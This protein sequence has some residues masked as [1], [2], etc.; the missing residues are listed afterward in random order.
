MGDLSG[1]D[2]DIQEFM[3]QNLGKHEVS[4]IK[5][6]RFQKGRFQTAQGDNKHGVMERYTEG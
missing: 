6:I 2:H 3:I 1:G 4:K 5:D